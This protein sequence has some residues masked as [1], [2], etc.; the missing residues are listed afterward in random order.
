MVSNFGLTWFWNCFCSSDHNEDST[1]RNS[2]VFCKKVSDES[3]ELFLYKDDRLMAFWDRSPAA[4]CHILVCPVVHVPSVRSLQ[5][6]PQSTKLVSDM[7]E[8]GQCLVAEH[9]SNQPTRF[10]F[11][12]PPFNSV[13]HLHLHCFALPFSPRWKEVKYTEIPGLPSFL[14]VHRLL[15]RL[16]R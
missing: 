4:A 12:M 7:L 13:D 5:S 16:N 3:D 10:G 6:G 1:L 9:S 15:Q 2:C 14:P 8:L 11:H